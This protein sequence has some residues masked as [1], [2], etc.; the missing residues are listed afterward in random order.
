[1]RILSLFIKG[2]KHFL[3]IEYILIFFL[4]IFSNLSFLFYLN[5]Y[6][7]KWNDLMT[8]E[9]ETDLECVIRQPFHIYLNTKS[10]LGYSLA[11]I[12]YFSLFKMP[13][14]LLNLTI[15]NITYN[16]FDF[17]II[18]NKL[19]EL[20]NYSLPFDSALFLTTNPQS[21]NISEISLHFNFTSFYSPANIF[22]DNISSFLSPIVNIFF[23]TQ[24][25]QQS[26][27]YDPMIILSKEY[28][29]QI[30]LYTN[31]D[32]LYNITANSIMQEY[33]SFSLEKRSLINKIPTRARKSVLT[34]N[35]ETAGIFTHLYYPDYIQT[36]LVALN[37]YYIFLDKLDQLIDSM[38]VLLVQLGYIFIFISSFLLLSFYLFLKQQILSFDKIL[39]LIY[40]R[41][42]KINS[43]KT[44]FLIVQLFIIVLSLVSSVLVS[45]LFLY[46]KKLIFWRYSLLV[47]FSINSILILAIL[48]FQSKL[49]KNMD[50]GVSA[51]YDKSNKKMSK[52][53]AIQISSKVIILGVILVSMLSL[54]STTQQQ[55]KIFSF[56]L[57]LLWSLSFILGIVLVLLVLT[58]IFI[59]TLFPIITKLF[60]EIDQS[61]NFISK[62]FEYLY[63]RK[64]MIWNSLFVILFIN[65]FMI[66]GYETLDNYDNEYISDSY[67]YDLSLYVDDR[68]IP[69]L[70]EIVNDSENAIAYIDVAIT[71]SP[72]ESYRSCYIYLEN[73]INFY[74]GT[75]FSRNYFKKYSNFEVFELL[76][77][78]DN[79]VITVRDNAKKRS[80]HNG[81]A[82]YLYKTT[83]NNTRVEEKKYLLDVFTF[84]P[85]FSHILTNYHPNLYIMKYNHSNYIP[86]N[87]HYSIFSTEINNNATLSNIFTYLRDNGFQ[88]SIIHLPNQD[89]ISP[90]NSLVQEFK[91]PIFTLISIT[92]I[93]ILIILFDIFKSGDKCLLILYSRGL[94]RRTGIVIFN[95]WIFIIFVSILILTY[96]Y[97]ILLNLVI[98]KVF[99]LSKIQPIKLKFKLFSYGLPIMLIAFSLLFTYFSILKF[100]LKKSRYFDK[101]Q[102]MVIK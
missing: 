69:Y 49:S 70:K 16:R 37:F 60:S 40:S 47:I 92:P 66:V 89:I 48:Q 78:S 30:L 14:V 39:D 67:C 31:D 85:F 55:F 99:N 26:H 19:L 5:N 74:L 22:I 15:R 90:V 38:N 25:L 88:Y 21:F 94:K 44:S 97:S 13:L 83:V 63:F 10:N 2:H 62:V 34:W 77:S 41:G 8:D 32:V 76:N 53:K 50:V 79:Y 72:F 58:P 98:L 6:H 12:D 29:D 80:Y 18:N 33:Y 65:S 59:Y 36:K 96:S 56:P 23:S 57:F 3:I 1:M 101:I 11:S 7:E 54:L 73:P 28:W 91:L 61:F 27:F 87:N 42:M 43:I 45:L 81:D 51:I 64:K 46:F 82:I 100:Q 68:A 75:N 20:F 95:L 17:F 93:V 102:K 24:E 9:E 71:S 84:I 52:S 4:L 86:S 35:I